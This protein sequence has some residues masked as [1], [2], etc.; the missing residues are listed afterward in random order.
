MLRVARGRIV[1]VTMDVEVL[2]Q[3]WVVRDYLPETL[4]AHA[5]GFP[6]IAR[7]IELLP[8]AA[9]AVIPVLRDCTEAS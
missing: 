3:L 7:L 4:T 1:L 8:G 6:S 2:G 9:A 5:V